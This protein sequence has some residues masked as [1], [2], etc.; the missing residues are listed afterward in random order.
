MDLKPGD[1]LTLDQALY[2]LM[3]CSGNDAANAIAEHISRQCRKIC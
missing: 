3:L 2:G 1:S